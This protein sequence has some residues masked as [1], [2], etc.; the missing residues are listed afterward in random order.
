MR[1]DVHNGVKGVVLL[2]RI[3]ISGIIARKRG[4][5]LLEFR[6]GNL[7]PNKGFEAPS[8]STLGHLFLNCCFSKF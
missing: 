7:A 1:D 6:D 2:M 4:V 3:Y 5:E 8:G